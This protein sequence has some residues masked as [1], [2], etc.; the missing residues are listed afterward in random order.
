MGS[1]LVAVPQA[2][3]AAPSGPGEMDEA[4]ARAA[5]VASGVRVEATALRT[6]RQQVFANPNG[7]FT[8]E[9]SVEPVRVRRGASWAPVDTTLRPAAGGTV[10]PGATTLDMAF[11]A[12]GDGPLVRL[13][14]DGNELAL[15]WPGRLPAP[16]LTG[17]TAT[18]PEVLPGVNLTLRATTEG[19]SQLLV[20]KSAQAAANPALAT[21]RL[22]TT[23]KGL[24]VRA[25][26][27]GSLAATDQ[28]GRAVFQAPT[29]YMWD[30]S[31]GTDARR[32][33][34][35][36]VRSM[37]VAVDP[38]EL[39]LVPDRQLLTAPGTRYPV[40][41]D[42]SWSG[43]KLA[44]TQVWSN[45]STTSFWNGAN[46]TEKV[47]RVGYDAT[48]GKLTRSFF[49]FDTT[50]IKGKHILKAT[51][52]TF[53]VWSRSCTAR[54][55]EVWATNPISS[56]TTWKN[57]P[58]WSYRMDYKSLAKGYS[59]SCPAGG[60][61]FD[62]TRQVVNAAA[63][64]WS[65]VTQGLRASSTAETNKD[66][67]SWKKFR[68]TPSIT[69][70][71]NT[72][73]GAPTNLTTEGS[74]TC[75]TGAGRLMLGTTKP[76]LRAT[77]SDVDNAVKAH[78]EWWAVDGTAPVGSYTSP[79]VAGKT[80]TVVAAAVPSGAFVNGSIAKW[81]VRAE[82]GTDNSAWS[83]WCEFQVDTTVPP[84]PTV[85]STAFPDG[86]EG[87]AVMGVNSSVTIGA[88]GGADI[89]SYE[90]TLNGAATAL[91]KKA[92]PAAEGE[93]VTITVTPDRFVNWL[94]VRSVDTASNRSEVATV[95]FYAGSPPG[96]V[97]DWALDETGDGTVAVDST[98]NARNA[99]LGGGA[100]WSNGVEGGALH[101]DG[102]S[103]YA[104]TAGPVVDA[105]KS[106]S[107]SAWVRL[108]NLSHN[109]VA[110]TQVGAHASTFTLYY[111]SYYKHWIFNR[112]PADADA[113]NYTRAVSTTVPAVD[114]WTHL[115]GV[116][117]APAQQIRLYV[118]GVLEATTAFTF[119]WAGA[120]GLQIGRSKV[121]SVLGEYFAG[122]IDAVKAYDRV[123][124][125]GELQQVPRLAGHWKLDET[126][127]TTAADSAG[128]HPATWSSTGVSRTAGVSGNAVAVDGISGVLTAS[129]PAVRTDGSYTVTAWVRPDSLTRNGI[130]VSQSGG[131]VSGFN[132]GYSWSDDYGMYL[133]SVRTSASDASG[134]ALREAV[135]P[136]DTP[137]T[138]TWAQLT[139]VYDAQTHQ[140]RLYVNGQAVAETAHAS[141]WNAGGGLLIGRGQAPNVSFP[142][143]F[144]G[145]IDEVRVYAGVLSDQ[146]IFDSYSAIAFP[147]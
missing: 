146:E 124:L 77:V 12:G 65:N 90:Y 24:A 5:A 145:G 139:A 105:M 38:G 91:D 52:Q 78:F 66:T 6:E 87:D 94:H 55:V 43:A 99:P 89:A 70:T 121:N 3:S 2:V 119:P 118:N 110:L 140:L 9:Q 10:M 147:Q 81:R 136:F 117:D 46:D 4:G 111:S 16:T 142:Q 83:T 31:G 57:Q 48:D 141:A 27:D 58:T 53:E 123:L 76:T 88:N 42:P 133:W 86:A 79:S 20:V 100:T 33:P 21:V 61:E 132:L 135:D 72:V 71:Y 49:R 34:G 44:W 127:G 59:S 23:T 96:P 36:R 7:T 95:V 29:P 14:R 120:G 104:A 73:P 15:H 19:F 138:G 113:D 74:A 108:T 129:G 92:A 1:A 82:D 97:G 41:I 28:A 63:G 106:F 62:V 50:G 93:S 56:S 51:L 122:D 37:R 143:Y 116:Y 109:S 125:P 17:D 39:A 115:A 137:I 22:R 134:S 114:T 130:A 80:P 67:L 47:G 128:G 13:R 26:A 30:S 131:A 101:L 45:L 18:Y 103:G 11:S 35:G 64:G 54:Q 102:V 75:T 85:S 107:V 112:T 144:T 98:A 68:S 84:I 40:Y 126:T 60:V 32:V 25:A 8:L 69:I